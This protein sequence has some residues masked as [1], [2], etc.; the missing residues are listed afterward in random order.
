MI[1]AVVAEFNPFHNGHAY[2]LSKA[3]ENCDA[4][5]A[6][7]SGNF[8]QRGDLAIYE[9]HLRAEFALKNGADLVVALPAGW[10]MSGAE[11]FAF[12]AVSVI[13]NLKIAE[14]IVFGCENDS[15]SLLNKTADILDSGELNLKIKDYL[16]K[17]ITYA[18]ARQQAVAEID[19]KC[20]EILSLP[21]NILAT[22]Y[23]RAAK[24][25]SFPAEFLP[26]KR[27]G[28]DHDSDSIIENVASASKIREIIKS[29]GDFSKLVPENILK[30]MHNNEAS[31]LAL[32]DSALLFKLRSLSIDNIKNLPDISE[33]IENRIYECIKTAKTF[34]E[35]CNKI[36]TKRY[37]YSRIK[38]ILLCACFGI[39]SSFLKAVPP[40]IHIIGATAKGIDMISAIHKISDTPIIVSAKDGLSLDGFAKKVFDTERVADDLYALSFKTPKN[41]GGALTYPLIKLN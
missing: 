8:V 33:G 32:I 31:D 20:S 11:N 41:S 27:I 19:G 40:Y 35:L 6:I 29:N 7:M 36:K 12:G 25:L 1:S 24:K 9:K 23:I 37:T 2:L 22:E 15:L 28:V 39:D 4:V 17:G 34:D 21:N 18:A 14:R 13:K 10:S 16:S 5:I 26:V 30:Q 3:K 38:R